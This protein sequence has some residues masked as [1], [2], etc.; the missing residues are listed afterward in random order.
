MV[1]NEIGVYI[2][3]S[4]TPHH[5]G[6]LWIHHQRRNE[7][8]TFQYSSKW[9]ASSHCFGLEPGLPPLPGKYHTDNALFGAIGDS[10]P[11]RWGRNLIKRL[12]MKA[13]KREKR[14]ARKLNESDFLL[15][16]DDFTRQGALRFS[17]DGTTF[18]TTYES[19]AI[20]P[21]VDLPKLLRAS[22][23]LVAN[24]EDEKDLR[25]LIAPGSSLGGARPKAA[26]MDGSTLLIAKFPNQYD[27]WDIPTWEYL[28][29]CMASQCGISTPQH[30]IYSVDGKNVLLLDRFDRKGKVRIPF[31][32]AMSML[33]ASDGEHKSYLD[34]AEALIS[35]GARPKQDLQELWKRMVF[36]IMTS[37]VD[38]HLRN[39]GFLYDGIGWQLSPVYDL[40][41][42][43]EH[44]KGRYLSTYITEDN[45]TASLE[46][47]FDVA[48]YFGLNH[49]DA[50]DIAQGICEVTQNWHIEAKRLNISKRDI[51]F[52]ETAF[53]HDDLQLGLNP[54]STNLIN[55][56]RSIK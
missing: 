53:E 25:D 27:D 3:I 28:S 36:N 50:R 56:N 26:I 47:A 17:I 19:G 15:L 35:Y 38:D 40:E 31:L 18:L 44:V 52:M 22:D 4:G 54:N 43:P 23:K 46:L 13:A 10:A 41:S 42:T 12:E 29:L 30:R 9:L 48:E 32:S 2:D 24:I 1:D 51:E 11:D 33:G 55:T 21:I 6:R 16:I 7:T 8:A 49:S 34:I 37:N 20:P 14:P 5:V 45:S 39:H